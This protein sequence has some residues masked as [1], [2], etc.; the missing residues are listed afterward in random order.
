VASFV[1]FVGVSLALLPFI[2]RDF[3][4]SVDAGLIKLHARGPPGTRIEESERRFAAT[5][6][7]I[8]KVIPPA[9]IDT[10][11]DNIG[12]PYSSINLSLSEGVLV[13]PADGDILISLKPE[14]KPTAGYVR[15]LRETFAR[16]FPDTTYFFLA[17]DISTQVLNFGL[18]APIDIQVVGP[19]GAED[20][21]QTV[22][23]RLMGRIAGIPGAVDVHLGQTSRIPELRI[24][25]D[26]TM[27][28]AFGMSERDV[29]SDMLVPFRRARSSRPAFGWTSA[30]CNTSSRCR[31]RSFRS[32]RSTLSRPRPSRTSA[33]N[34]SSCRTS[35]PCRVRSARRASRTT[36]WP[37]P[38]TYK[39]TSMAPISARSPTASIAWSMK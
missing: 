26:R 6:D 15:V 16:Q 33:P 32:I 25:V 36:T 17:P 39:P 35:R 20:A 3:F 29:A 10:M 8:R 28:Q 22:A 4:P 31:P 2:G 11:L 12:V 27:A 38:T 23:A 19:I 7:A 24:D 9:E 13:S 30:A 5:E 37:V 18:P 34:R 14:H 21:T 1:A